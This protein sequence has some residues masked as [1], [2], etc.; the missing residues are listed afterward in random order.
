M[1]PKIFEKNLTSLVSYVKSFYRYYTIQPEV[2]Q[3]VEG[4]DRYK[5][6]VK[7]GD[8]IEFLRA[9]PGG[10][11]RGKITAIVESD[12]KKCELIYPSGYKYEIPE[13]KNYAFL[14]YTDGKRWTSKESSEIIKI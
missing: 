6:I 11:C 9:A 14:I 8:T 3:V 2:K 1:N 4:K 10:L 7:V 13:M 5:K 12:I